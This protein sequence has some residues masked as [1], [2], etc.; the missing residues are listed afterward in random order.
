MVFFL[1]IYRGEIVERCKWGR[2]AET[3]TILRSD[4]RILLVTTKLCL[5]RDRLLQPLLMRLSFLVEKYTFVTNTNGTR[6]TLS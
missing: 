1:N 2:V 5:R 4:A 6:P 3:A